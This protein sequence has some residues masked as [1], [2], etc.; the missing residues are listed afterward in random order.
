MKNLR[1]SLVCLC[2]ILSSLSAS[3]QTVHVK[4]NEPDLNKPLL[5]AALPDRIPVSIDYINSLFGSAK[6]SSVSL[7]TSEDARAPRIEGEVISTGSKYDNR[8]ESVMIRSTNFEGA[9]FRVSKYTDEQGVA[10]YSGRIISFQHGDAYE[11]KNEDGNFF[12]IKTK[13]YSLVN[14]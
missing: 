2:V 10:R 4:L 12:L 5:F 6:G 13:F 3:A 1:T 11:L 14:E 9:R 7:S 8:L